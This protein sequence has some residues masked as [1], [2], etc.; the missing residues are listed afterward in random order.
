MTKDDCMKRYLQPIN[1]ILLLA[2]PVIASSML[3]ASSTQAAT[4][5][6]SEATFNIENFNRNP[7]DIRTITDAVTNTISTDGQ[8][9]TNANA[10]ANFNADPNALTFAS[11]S[12]TSKAQG[13]GLSYLGEGQSFAAVLGYDFLVQ[14]GETFSFDFNGLLDLKTSID[15]PTTENATANGLLTFELYDSGSNRLLDSFSIVGSLATPGND[16]ALEVQQSGSITL[17]P[18]QTYF[19]K[20]FGGTQEIAQATVKGKYSR[21]F[22]KSTYLTLIE[23]KT[24]QVRVQ[25]KV[26]EPS[27]AFGLVLSCGVFTMTWKRKHK[28]TTSVLTQN[29]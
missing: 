18:T 19:N 26:P 21:T 1:K 5:G 16:D 8:V 24:N 22:D 14:P 9:I 6:T 17:D 4:L 11:N 10:N 15:N 27:T 12:S 13:E 28:A 25:A 20:S 29:S 7:L 23:S 3:A 2:T